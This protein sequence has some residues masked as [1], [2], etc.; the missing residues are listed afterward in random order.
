[1]WF[2]FFRHGAATTRTARPHRPTCTTARLP[3]RL[4]SLAWVSHGTVRE[5]G[6]D[7]CRR[8]TAVSGTGVGP[9]VRFSPDGRWIA[10]GSGLVVPGPGR[11]VARPVRPLGQ[12]TSWAWSLKGDRLAGITMSGRVV[13]GGVGSRPATLVPFGARTLAWSPDG[14]SLAVGMGHRLGVVSSAGGAPTILYSGPRK[15]SIDVIDWS[16]GGNWVLFFQRSPGRVSSA[17]DAAPISGGG[18]H[19]VFDPVL[20]YADFLS[21]CGSTLALSGGGGGSASQGQQI[22]TSAPPDWRTSDLSRDF[23]TSW[24]WPACSPSGR[25]IA[26]TL[27]PNHVELPPG[28]GRR[29]L[30]VMGTGG[31]PRRRLEAGSNRAFEVPRWSADGRYV[32]VIVR[33]VQPNAPGRFVLVRIDPR[34]GRP[35]RSIP[36][37]DRTGPVAVAGAPGRNGHSE[38]TSVVDWYRPR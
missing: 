22:L 37:R 18:Y 28:S 3:G 27:T 38:W 15:D 11:P 21:W 1:V 6:L 9:P 33:G 20:P 4:G 12:V 23:R 26:I 32:L 30:W 10:Y 16:P 13:V 8:S 19:N 17:L 31:H 7:S 14:R 25:W 5:F 34:T 24:I 35:L 29:S 2:A 36:I